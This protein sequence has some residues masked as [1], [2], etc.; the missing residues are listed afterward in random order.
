MPILPKEPDKFPVDLFDREFN[1]QEKTWWAAYTLSR[2]DKDLMRALTR[3]EIWF[4]APTIEKR[5]KSPAGRI[6]SSYIPLFMNY[7]FFWGTEDQREQALKSN[8]I[9]TL[10]EIVDEKIFEKEIRQIDRALSMGAEVLPESRMSSG[11]YIR[12]KN[13]PFKDFEGVVLRREGK[14]RLLL[15]LKFLEQGVSI[16]LDECQLVKV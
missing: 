12:V 14:K 15:S 13:G 7:V 1:C 4:Y 9:A 5:H 6:R 8:C 16:E 11:D 3:N 2:R 10:T